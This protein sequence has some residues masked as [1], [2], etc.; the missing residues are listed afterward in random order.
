[1]IRRGGA[2]GSV[3]VARGAEGD[4]VGGI[5]SAGGRTGPPDAAA[6]RLVPVVARV[7]EL[8]R[9]PPALVEWV[10]GQ[11]DDDIALVLMEYTGSQTVTAPVPSWEVGA[12]EL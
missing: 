7:I 11:L 5:E 1:M 10:R 8:G 2:S 6:S 9:G 3:T 12:T 4:A